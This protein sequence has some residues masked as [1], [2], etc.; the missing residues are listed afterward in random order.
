MRAN[1]STSGPGPKSPASKKVP[2]PT[3]RPFSLQEFEDSEARAWRISGGASAAPRRND[4][5]WS[6]R[7]P[8]R[9]SFGSRRGSALIDSAFHPYDR[10]SRAIGHGH[11]EALAGL[12]TEGLVERHAR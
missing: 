7:K 5:F 12:E 8:T 1:M 11:L 2:G 3:S 10:E 6:Q 9:A 4:E